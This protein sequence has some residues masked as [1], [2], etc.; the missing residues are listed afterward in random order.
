MF[1]VYVDWTIEPQPRPF[2]VGKG[3]AT[4]LH[5]PIRNPRHLDIVKQHGQ[6]RRVCLETES[7]STALAEEARLMIELKTIDGL[8]GNWG[9]NVI[10]G[11]AAGPGS[12]NGPYRKDA[13]VHVKL[14]LDV[15]HALRGRAFTTN[16]TV[17][18]AF[19]AFARAY[20]AGDEHLLE[21]IE[22]ERLRR[23]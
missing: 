11:G 5:Q 13:C 15:H 23:L 4:R 2:Y 10:V 18:L 20:A 8:P 7:E 21:L 19:V 16:T 9:A 22:R 1:Y 12:A 17:Q 6:Q 3:N 14:P